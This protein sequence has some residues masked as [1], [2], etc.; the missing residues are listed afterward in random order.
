LR[1]ALQV[2]LTATV[3]SLTA[4]FPENNPGGDKRRREFKDDHSGLPTNPASLFSRFPEA[5]FWPVSGLPTILKL[6][7]T[8][9]FVRTHLVSLAKGPERGYCSHRAFITSAVSSLGK[10]KSSTS[11]LTRSF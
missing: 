1:F 6:M 2:V 11:V 9:A 7:A 3:Q 4:F 5:R 8:S 10:V